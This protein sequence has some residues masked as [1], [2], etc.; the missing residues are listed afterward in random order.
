MRCRE[1]LQ[2]A[3]AAA[4]AAEQQ[5]APGSNSSASDGG[6][7][8]DAGDDAATTAVAAG[9]LG[10]LDYGGGLPSQHAQHAGHPG[11]APGN[12]AAA[13]AGPDA[14][15]EA[16]LNDAGLHGGNESANVHMHECQPGSGML[17]HALPP[18][19]EPSRWL[20][21][22]VLATRACCLRHGRW[23]GVAGRV[24]LRQPEC[25]LA[26]RCCMHDII[27]HGRS[28]MPG[29]PCSFCSV[30]MLGALPVLCYASRVSG[31]DLQLR[32]SGPLLHMYRGARRRRRCRRRCGTCH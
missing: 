28:G 25:S 14:A 1:V 26:L 27:V 16:E 22:A 20:Q 29:R 13:T 2:E 4:A 8:A 19:R 17:A 5:A 30:L 23:R 9:A 11:K 7:G 15:S 31:V 6:S 24:R 18:V 12:A 21:A 32:V 10:I 3:R